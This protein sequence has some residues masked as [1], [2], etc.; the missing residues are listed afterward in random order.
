MLV[1]HA[2]SLVTQWHTA[3]MEMHRSVQPHLYRGLRRFKTP[4]IKNLPMVP[5]YFRPHRMYDATRQYNRFERSEFFACLSAMR[6]S[7]DSSVTPITSDDVAVILDTGASLLVI[8]DSCL[9]IDGCRPVADGRIEGIGD[10]LTITGIGMARLRFTDTKGETV[11]IDVLAL[12]VPDCPVN[13]LPPQQ[14][15]ASPGMDPS[16]CAVIHDDGIHLWYNGHEIL[17]PYDK[18]NNL[19]IL[20]QCAGAA[21]FT[22]KCLGLNAYIDP[23]IAAKQLDETKVRNNSNLSAGMQKL[24]ELHERYGHIDMT[25]IQDWARQ[26]RHGIPKAVGT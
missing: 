16:N 6:S 18:Q 22:A 14:L 26:G 19:P 8:N 4:N 23:L 13:L 25:V 11:H 2:A 5:D 10:G 1:P 21:A 3:A 12:L 24:L 9:L 17:F 15:I 20:K 7:M